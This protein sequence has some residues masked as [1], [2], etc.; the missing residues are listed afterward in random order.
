LALTGDPTEMRLMWV[1][2]SK[3]TP[4]V[5]Y[6]TDPNALNGMA[7]GT[8]H[9]YA[10]DDMCGPPANVTGARN[11]RD[12][13]QIHD[14]LITGLV[15]QTTYYYQYGDVASKSV[16]VQLFVT[17]PKPSPVA[18]LTIAIYGDMGEGYLIPEAATTARRIVQHL[19]DWSFLL[20]I[21][22]ISY[23]RGLA[24]SWEWFFYVIMPIG[25]RIPYM[26]GIGNHEYDHVVGGEH[27]PS[28]ASGTGWHPSWGNFGDDSS[29]ECARPVFER[30]HMPDNG[31]SLFWYS[32]DYGSA[33]I[34][35]MST[36]HDFTMG[37]PQIKWLI[38]DLASVNRKVTPWL[39][40]AGHRPMYTSEDYPSDYLVSLHMQT[41]FESV[42]HQYGVDLAVWGHYHAY[43]RT[44]AVFNQTCRNDGTVHIVVG[45]AGA[46]IDDVD[47][48]PKEWSLV[49]ANDFGYGRLEITATGQ[50][51][52]LNWQFLFN[53]NDTVF[54]QVTLTKSFDS[55][56]I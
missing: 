45:T 12:P 54:D 33:H 8:S 6:G 2:D 3:T 43:E 4:F 55:Y 1:S 44:C 38:Q 22:D 35:H 18:P 37:S 50:Q 56:L 13:G 10:A 28:G 34:V 24:Y 11:F 30:F 46:S 39:I 48:Y 29:G 49:H 17:A 53:S 41:E 51:T 40:L 47:W 19:D 36:E 42:L 7:T 52:S 23:A 9:T 27:D 31:L 14:V 16:D 21:G 5:Q 20:H 32:F 26:I 15:P 25:V